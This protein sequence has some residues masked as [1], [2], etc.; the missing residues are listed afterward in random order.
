MTE[1]LDRADYQR[2]FPAH[3]KK[4]KEAHHLALEIRKFEIELYWRRATYFWTLIGAS[5]VAYGGAQALNKPQVSR[6]L[7]RLY[8]ML[9]FGGFVRLVLRKSRKQAVAGE[10]GE[11]R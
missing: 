5:L 8:L 4:R 9:W 1:R 11:S 2:A 6:D 3:S 7:F 10:L